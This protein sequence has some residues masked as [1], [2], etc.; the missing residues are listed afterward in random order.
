MQRDGIRVAPGD[1]FGE[2]LVMKS[3]RFLNLAALAALLMSVAARAESS[4]NQAFEVARGAVN[5]D[6]Q[7][8]VVSIYGIGTPDA[9]QKWYII[10]Y[11]ASVQSHGRAV[12]VEN[13]QIARTYSANGGTT[14]R[15]DLTFDPSRLTSEGPALSAAQGYAAK[16]Y[17]NYDTVHAL[18]K[19]SSLNRPFRW[20]IELLSSGRSRGY[21]YIN[22][23]DSTVASFA[24]AE[25]SGNQSGTDMT[26]DSNNS[27]SKRHSVKGD[28]EGFG[29]D[30]KHTFLGIG[31]DLQEFF[32][33]ERTVDRD[34]DNN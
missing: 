7:T 16:H 34:D 17:I 23:L 2:N 1:E 32:T 26:D 18:L 3:F 20:R 28:A 5:P 27:S 13:G 15:A 12:L 29:N 30:V 25:S 24:P 33:G 4:V 9:I 8:K 14:Y 21:V 22:A 6:L 31:G 11:D 10:F 19:Q